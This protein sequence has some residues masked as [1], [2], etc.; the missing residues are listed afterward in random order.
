MDPKN[1]DWRKLK[2][3]QNLHRLLYTAG[4]GPIIGRI[5]LL[6]TT[7]GRKSGLPRVTPLQ[8]ELIDK[9][10]CLGSARGR[11]ADWV[12]NIEADPKVQVRVKR[13]NFSGTARI[14]NDVNEIANF[15]EIRLQRHPLMIGLIMQKTHNL[16]RRPSRQQLEELAKS[17]V[18]VV[19]TPDWD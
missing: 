1:F 5:I 2:K 8:Y 19:I 10:Y 4:L 6:L 7:T 16:P 11:Q 15:L 12:R 9:S 18:M 14:S 13:L 17:E 3:A